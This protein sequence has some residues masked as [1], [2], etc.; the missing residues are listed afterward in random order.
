MYFELFHRKAS[1]GIML[2]SRWEILKLF[3]KLLQCNGLTKKRYFLNNLR[4]K[5]SD[6]IYSCHGVLMLLTTYE[7]MYQN[8]Q[9]SKMIKKR[10]YFRYS[11][12]TVIIVFFSNEL[13]YDSVDKII[14]LCFMLIKMGIF[15]KLLANRILSITVEWAGSD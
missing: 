2:L 5:R 10:L 13:K 8:K 9:K 11:I 14:Q 15:L 7:Q 1:T 6:D 4:E 3:L 12:V